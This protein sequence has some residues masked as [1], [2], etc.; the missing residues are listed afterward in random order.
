LE[1]GLE[2][3]LFG[4]SLFSLL[5]H[6]NAQKTNSANFAF[7]A[8]SEVPTPA[9]CVAPPLC[10]GI[11]YVEFEGSKPFIHKTLSGAEWWDRANFAFAAFSEVPLQHYA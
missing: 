11:S 3:F 10:S 7:A 2:A 8:F 6:G 5:F 1:E 9:L 4:G